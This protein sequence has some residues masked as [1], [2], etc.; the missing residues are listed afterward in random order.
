LW[1]TY[2]S[3]KNNKVIAPKN[4]LGFRIG[5]EHPKCI[6]TKKFNWHAVLDEN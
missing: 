5:K 2:L 1:A 3:K 6:M 4:W